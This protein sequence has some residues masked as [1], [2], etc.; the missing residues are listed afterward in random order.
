MLI[1]E[2]SNPLPAR[3]RTQKST[4][5]L[6]GAYRLKDRQSYYQ[7][8]ALSY[9]PFPNLVDAHKCD[10]VIVGGDYTGL[11]AA[12]ELAKK[13]V[14]VILLEQ[15]KIGYGASGRNGGQLIRGW[16]WE[17]SDIDKKF[18]KNIG[19][20]AWQIGLDS[21]QLVKDRVKEYNIDC[22][23]KAGYNHAPITARQDAHLQDAIAALAKRNYQMTYI[24]QK[25]VGTKLR[26]DRYISFGEDMHSGHLHPLKLAIGYAQAAKK[27]GAQIYEFSP[28]LDL[29][30]DNAIV[31]TPSGRVQA[32]SIILAG[33]AYLNWQRKLVKKLYD[34]VMPVGSYIIATEPLKKSDLPI[35]DDQAYCDLNWVLDYF[36][37]SADNRLLF[38]GRATYSTLEPTD[39]R[40]WMKPRLVNVFPHLKDAR[41]D[42]GWGGVID[43]TRSRLPE[44]NFLTPRTLF[45]QGFSGQGVNMAGYCGKILAETLMAEKRGEKQKQFEMISRFRHHTFPGGLL[46][47][48]L[49]VM[50]MTYYRLRDKF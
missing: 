11:S 43:I 16:H 40:S 32:D 34:T 6:S 28:A 39:V 7:D 2:D 9:K 10:V 8:S 22:D 44:M 13:N 38:G 30:L 31:T 14:K 46:R 29:D 42:Y 45:V 1:P 47:M 23:L 50:A 35:L 17:Q 19:D 27:L 25:D 4:C 3:Y 12:I 26:S 37:L 49:L 48:P 21:V 36:R 24:P 15:N 18:G 33:G 5:A 20:I 41:I